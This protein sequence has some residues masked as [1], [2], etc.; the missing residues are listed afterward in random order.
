MTK[1][2]RFLAGGGLVVALGLVLI[3]V[4]GVF[5]ASSVSAESPPGRPARFAG[6]V[7][8]D[9]APVPSGT[10]IEAR[11]NNST[12]G[13]T[14][15]FNSGSEA[16]YVLDVPALDP[17]ASPNCGTDGA[18]VSFWIG[19]RQ[20]RETGSWKDFDLNVL[21]LSYVTP[22]TP[23][24]AASVTTTPG[25]GSGPAVTPRPPATGNA[26]LGGG[27]ST[28]L[29]VGLGVVALAFGAAGAVATRRSR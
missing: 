12:C 8:V 16:R 26:G 25:G 5:N 24:P 9:G 22:P 6:S 11:I 19:D 27:E 13:V 7:T 4:A 23:T 29:L 18:A 21:N 17:G 2:L 14:T 28:L 3:S 15:T 20:A 10:R 1:A